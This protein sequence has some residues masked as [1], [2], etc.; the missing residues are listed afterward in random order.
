MGYVNSVHQLSP[1]YTSKY[2]ATGWLPVWNWCEAISWI[3][4]LD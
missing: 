1:I 4:Y 2:Q 3:V